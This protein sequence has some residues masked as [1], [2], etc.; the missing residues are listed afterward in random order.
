ML[1]LSRLLLFY[2][3]LRGLARSLARALLGAVVL[4]TVV[5]SRA[6]IAV[7]TNI[8][9]PE[10]SI[11]LA[12]LRRIYL[13]ETTSWEFS[14]QRR[15]SITLL[16]YKGEADVGEAFYRIIAQMSP[17]R[18]RLK[19]LSMILNGEFQKLPK[20]TD[21]ERKLVELIGN[22]VGAIG[23]LRVVD[24]DPLAKSVKVLKIDGKGTGDRDY[25]LRQQSAGD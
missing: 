1:S 9:N 11:T 6:Q 15:E 3:N 12:E 17:T 4:L 14:E 25:P 5:E 16:D 21:S 20:S 23:F 22:D 10:S 7:V 24:L 18:I 19:W 13:G 2:P 8:A